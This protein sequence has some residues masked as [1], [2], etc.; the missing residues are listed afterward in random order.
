MKF[1]VL[2][3][4][5]CTA[6]PNSKDC[7]KHFPNCYKRFQDVPAVC[8]GDDQV[9]YLYLH[10][11]EYYK[12]L[13]DNFSPSTIRNY[14]GFVKTA[15]VHVPIVQTLF[16]EEQRVSIDAT[17]SDLHKQGYRNANIEIAAKKKAGV[18]PEHP[19]EV[20]DITALPTTASASACNPDAA[21]LLLVE[22]TAKH[23]LQAKHDQLLAS[24]TALEESFTR[25][26]DKHKARIE[27][28]EMQLAAYHDVLEDIKVFASEG[29]RTA[30]IKDKLLEIINSIN[31]AAS[32]V[33]SDSDEAVPADVAA[34]SAPASD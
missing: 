13:C 23:S 10:L 20:I 26:A 18:K 21:Q 12:F 27:D 11:T 34:D 19:T 17:M 3:D 8:N 24:Y 31:D 25:M 30:R 15:W 6:L 4:H 7:T 14:T 32:D 1:S 5:V 16:T 28:L 9:Q 2:Y 29:I 22:L 33:S